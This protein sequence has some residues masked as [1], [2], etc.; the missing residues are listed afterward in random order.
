MGRSIATHSK[1]RKNFYINWHEE[2]GV[3][4]GDCAEWEW[5]EF[6][7]SLVR[8]LTDIS[9]TFSE[10]YEG[11]IVEDEVELVLSNGHSKIMLSS[12]VGLAAV[13]IVS[14]PF[15][16]GDG[17]GNIVTRPNHLSMHY[18]DTTLEPKLKSKLSDRFD[19]YRAGA[20]ASNGNQLFHKV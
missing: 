13:G 15:R 7:R 16:I 5:R 9:D 2:M 8:M 20:T 19:L 3:E 6:K 18:C 10:P 4:P 17:W 12:Y 1:S 14:Q 11:Q